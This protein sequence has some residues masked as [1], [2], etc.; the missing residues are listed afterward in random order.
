MSIQKIPAAGFTFNPEVSTTLIPVAGSG[1]PTPANGVLTFTTTGAHGMV[2]GQ[3]V[4]FTTTVSAV[5]PT[6]YY[7]KTMFVVLSVPST[8]TFTIATANTGQVTTA[9]TAVPIFLT[10]AG[11]HFFVTGANAKVQYNPDNTG[12]VQ[13][14]D[15][16]S[17]TNTTVPPTDTVSAPVP[18]SVYNATWRDVVAVSSAGMV[19]MD[20]FGMRIICSGGA[21]TTV[22]SNIK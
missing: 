5:A 1:T 21:G 14:G 10:K 11:M 9:G 22:W 4:T 19:Y 2:A 3:G 20:G 16:L 6:D 12:Y 13:V 17:S 7:T 8:T 15:L 18:T